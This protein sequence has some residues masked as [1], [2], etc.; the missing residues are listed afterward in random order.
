MDLTNYRCCGIIRDMSNYRKD[1]EEIQKLSDIFKALSN[2]N[3]LR[4]F[5]RLVMCCSEG[6]R[7]EVPPEG[8]ACIGELGQ[9]LSIVPS[10]I[11]HHIKELH[12]AGLIQTERDGQQI[13][14]WI[15]P[16]M[17]RYL[18]EF[19]TYPTCQ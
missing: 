8:C 11:S 4:I 14:C 12:R 2:S 13:R 3:R 19:F 7:W 10:T 18:A 16:E 1:D 5:L 15:E 6:T 9:D 17:L